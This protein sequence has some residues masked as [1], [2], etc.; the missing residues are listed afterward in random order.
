[1]RRT[2]TETWK[3]ATTAR[4]SRLRSPA[5][6]ARSRG[7]RPRSSGGVA[8]FAGL[9]DN[10]AETIT[11]QFTGGGLTSTPTSSIVVSPAAA[12]RLVI[13][14]Q[15]STTATAGQ[16]FAIQP[17]IYEEDTY[18]NLETGDNGT[19]VTA[20]LSSGSGPLQGTVTAVVSGGVAT[21]SNLAD[22]KA[23]TISLQFTSGS[24]SKS[25][26]GSIV[27]SPAAASQLVIHTQPSATATAGRPFAIQPVIY[28]EDSYGN[29]ETADHSTV[30]TAALSSG[31]GPLQGTVTAVVSG[32]VATFSNLADNKAET[33]SLQ[34]TSGSLV[35]AVSS[36]VVVSPAAASKLVLV[37][38]P[39]ETATAGQPFSSQPVLY[40][41]DQYGNLETGDNST[42][43]TAVLSSGT[44]PLQGTTAIVVGGVASF[45]GLADNKAETITL[46][47]TGG[48]LT[49]S[50]T[51]SIVVSPAAPS[52]LVI[53]HAA[54][55]LGARAAAI[56]NSTGH[57]HRGSLRQPGD[58]RQQHGRHR[59]SEQRRRPA[60]GHDHG[61]RGGRLGPLHEPGRQQGRVHHAVVHRRWPDSG[62][63][64]PGRRQ[65]GRGS[66]DQLVHRVA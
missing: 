16:A 8:T 47:F 18:G 30:V 43:V 10:R 38:Q 17:V 52:Q 2:G 62:G 37:Q 9:V 6:L 59:G 20:A 22:N 29:I 34:F 4:C 36:P 23:E 50:S 1:M 46:R 15:P 55:S 44:G 39:A 31:A 28:E 12:S 65:P 11:L 27:V 32:G 66:E 41:E 57:L 3:Q 40:E 53:Q 14:T 7:R 54:V 60:P 13:H 49:S 33:I 26:S 24:L 35:P 42:V 51:N 48:G 56:R 25:I 45:A 21:F 64:Q 5:G 61:D 19:V 58:G 63:L